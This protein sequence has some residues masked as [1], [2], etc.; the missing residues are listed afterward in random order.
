MTAKSHKII[1]GAGDNK[2]NPSKRI[3]LQDMAIIVDKMS[4]ILNG[5]S[6]VDLTVLEKYKDAKDISKYA[7]ASLANM[8]KQEIIKTKNNTILKPLD[9]LNRSDAADTV[10][11]LLMKK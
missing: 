2:F 1:A 9:N 7:A 5:S 4:R 6:K 10:Y 8:L 11:N 3:T